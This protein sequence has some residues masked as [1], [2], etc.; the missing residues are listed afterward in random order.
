MSAFFNEDENYQLISLFFNY[1]FVG[2]FE[3]ARASL[4]NLYAL[5]HS[6]HHDKSQSLGAKGESEGEASGATASSYK[7][8]ELSSFIQHLVQEGVP[9]EW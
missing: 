8:T 6:P 3:L 2:E 1:I 9:H 4:R 7:E 5:L